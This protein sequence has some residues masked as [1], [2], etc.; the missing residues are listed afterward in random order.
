MNHMRPIRLALLAAIALT[1]CAKAEPITVITNYF[2]GYVLITNGWTTAEETG[3]S[4]GV[5]YVAIP[6]SAIANA[7]EAALVASGAGSDVRV[8]LW[9]IFD[10]GYEAYTA[11][12]STNR[13]VNSV[14]SKTTAS[15]GTTS[16]QT[17]HSLR[18]RFTLSTPVLT[19]E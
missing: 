9:G 13:P 2:P 19:P 8:L 7:T 10:S 11:L 17:T 3:L 1:A 5:A 16:Y 4:N 6:L 18:T 15:S 12:D 14:L